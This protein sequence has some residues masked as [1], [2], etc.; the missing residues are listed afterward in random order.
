[1]FFASIFSYSQRGGCARSRSTRRATPARRADSR[2]ARAARHRA[3]DATAL[4]VRARHG[5]RADRSAAAAS[6]VPRAQA[7]APRRA[8]SRTRSIISSGSSPACARL[9]EGGSPAGLP[10]ATG[11]TL[12]TDVHAAKAAAP[13]ARAHPRDGARALQ[14][15]RRAARHDGRHRRRDEHQPGQPL[16]PLPQQGRDHRLAVRSARGGAAPL[17]A[18]PRARADVEDLWLFLHLLFERMWEYRFF[19]R[20]LDEITSRDR[21]LATRFADTC[22]RA[23]P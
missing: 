16:L 12:R 1:M 10:R 18:G 19:Y 13:H 22:A 17:L 2:P 3:A 9:A 8:S 7:C 11:I 21:K 15:R 20:D 5:R 6:G 4:L 23:K 14:S